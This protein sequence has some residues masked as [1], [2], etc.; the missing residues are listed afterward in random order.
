MNQ[1]KKFRLSLGETQRESA[2]KLGISISKY[3][4]AEQG[5]QGVSDKLK[6]KMANHFKTT[7]E[8]LFFENYITY[9]DNKNESVSTS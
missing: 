9:S 8:I 5:I 1:L 3:Q 2:E 7:V 6:V 4:K